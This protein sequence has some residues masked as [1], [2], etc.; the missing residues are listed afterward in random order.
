MAIRVR[1]SS[2]SLANVGME[3]T[4]LF[5]VSQYR[6]QGISIRDSSVFLKFRKN[7]LFFW[8][9]V[10]TLPSRN[11]WFYWNTYNF[12]LLYC[13]GGTRSSKKCQRCISSDPSEH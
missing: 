8:S 13:L 10:N 9:A 2:P 6:C 11:I 3:L 7:K 12:F 1:N 5:N 4:F